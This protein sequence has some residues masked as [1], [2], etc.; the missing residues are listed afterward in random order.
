MP[1]SMN[2]VDEELP[3]DSSVTCLIILDLWDEKKGGKKAQ[4]KLPLTE[5][6]GGSTKY[7][8]C[9]QYAA[10]SFK[11]ITLLDFKL[12]IHILAQRQ[13]KI[14]ISHCK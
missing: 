14:I 6:K 8:H 3:S 11:S 4:A 9:Q 13:L 12:F 1:R 5:M 7:K 10:A 2:N